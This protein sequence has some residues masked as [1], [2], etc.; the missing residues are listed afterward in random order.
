MEVTAKPSN[1][2]LLEAKGIGKNFGPI[3]AVENVN[4]TVHSSEVLAL[5]GD[6]GAG[7]S[8]LIQMLYGVITP[9][10]GQLLWNGKPVHLR[11]PRDGMNLGISVVFQD[12]AIVSELS[13]FRNV[14]LGREELVSR[15]I[16][17]FH[18]F[19]IKRA[20]VEA[21]RALKDVG[22]HVRSVDEPVQS[23]SG[24]ERQS[25]AIARANYFCSKL[26]ILDEPTAALSL[27]ET[28]K[29]LNYI[30]QARSTG[31]AV[32]VISHNIKQIF[33]VADR[34]TVLSLGR[35]VGTFA[36]SEVTI[37]QLSELIH[38]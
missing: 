4:L 23:L 33:P 26:L 6:N 20:R 5:L 36:K 10:S 38:S 18:I 34:F 22:I 21:G 12:L 15:K 31:L 19:D 7:K 35:C 32:I 17:P 2:P 9:D 1:A 30:D 29:V 28:A 11:S 24:G 13:I 8:T 37:E 14:F 3:N 25:I 27:K 16:G